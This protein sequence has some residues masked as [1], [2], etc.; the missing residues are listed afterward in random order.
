[1]HKEPSPGPSSTN[2]IFLGFPRFRNPLV[3]QRRASANASKQMRANAFKM[4]YAKVL[5]C[6]AHL[7]LGAQELNPKQR[8]IKMMSCPQTEQKKQRQ[9]YT[10]NT[11]N[12]HSTNKKGN[13]T[14]REGHAT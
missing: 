6:I 8:D 13:E 12:E 5:Y 10:I 14:K 3:P 2:I 1:M 11:H 9:K 4:F 7:A